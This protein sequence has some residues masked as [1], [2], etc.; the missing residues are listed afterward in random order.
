MPEVSALAWSIVRLTA[1][2]TIF[3]VVFSIGL[4]FDPAEFRW[5]IRRPWLLVRGLFSVFVAVP[6]TAVLV[7]DAIGLSRVAQVAVALI[8]IA[9]GAPVALRRSIQAGSHHSAAVTMHGLVVL[10]AI[11]S[12]PLSIQIL[13][14]I[15]GTHASIAPTLVAMSVFKTQLLPLGIGLFVRWLAP[16]FAQRVE[17]LVRR[18]AS[19]LLVAFIA[20]TLIALWRLL[21]GAAPGTGLAAAIVTGIAL[22]TGHVLGGPDEDTRRALALLSAMRNPGLALL[23]AAANHAP[24]ELVSTVLAYGLLSGVAVTPYV[25]WR[26]RADRR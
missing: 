25:I 4:A 21:L 3:T 10:V 1:A 8:S 23:V 16:A 9:P 20:A 22:A 17:P 7:G 15:Y 13:N 19:L 6:I 11:V 26:R 14:R 24:A 12:M 2:A 18:V 5:A